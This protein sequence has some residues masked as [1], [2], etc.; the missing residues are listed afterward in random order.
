MQDA[1][2]CI[3]ASQTASL[4]TCR[5]APRSTTGRIKSSSWWQTTWGWRARRT[6]WRSA[7]RAAWSP[8]TRSTRTA[9]P[10][11]PRR[12]SWVAPGSTSSSGDSL[13]RRPPPRPVP[14]PPPGPG[15]P[16]GAPPLG[17]R[18]AWLAGPADLHPCTSQGAAL[19]PLSPPATWGPGEIAGAGAASRAAVWHQAAIENVCT[20]FPVLQ[21]RGSPSVV[22]GPGSVSTLPRPSPERVGNAESQGSPQTPK[23]E[24]AFLRWSACFGKHSSRTHR[25][26]E[27]SPLSFMSVD[28]YSRAPGCGAVLGA[29]DSYRGRSWPLKGPSTLTEVA[30]Y[31]KAQLAKTLSSYFV[32]TAKID[33]ATLTF[34]SALTGFLL[35]AS[36]PTSKLYLK[37]TTSGSWCVK[38]HRHSILE[39]CDFWKPGCSPKLGSAAVLFPQT[40]G[41]WKGVIFHCLLFHSWLCAC[42]SA[43][44]LNKAVACVGCNYGW[45]Q[46]SRRQCTCL[47]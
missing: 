12:S 11:R 41:R 47:L 32:R 33:F 2:T 43:G 31:L 45:M 6:S 40:R 34:L 17:K 14:G 38:G 8:P 1:P 23:S 21:V 27:I 25:A 4:W 26:A 9:R 28:E 5:R 24:P 42:Q 13:S 16:G 20:G 18:R 37:T 19:Q 10:P 7:W 22:P 39:R 30:C 35:I 46:I 15:S 29:G 36:S 3:A 44:N